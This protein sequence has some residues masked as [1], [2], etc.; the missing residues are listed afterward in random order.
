MVVLVAALVVSGASVAA[1]RGWLVRAGV[2][3]R[4]G[5]RSSHQVPTPRGGGLGI[6]AGFL[7]G[8]A[9]SSWVLPAG[10]LWGLDITDSRLTALVAG[11]LLVAAV[12]L[13]DDLHSLPVG[14]RLGAQTVGAVVAI[15]GVGTLE[16]IRLP[17]VGEARLGLLEI[18]VT[19]LWLVAVTNIYN[20]MDGIDGLAAGQAA[21]AGAFLALSALQT[22]NGAVA[23]AA[24][25]M[26]GAALGFLA[27]N[28]PP[29]RIFMGDVGSTFL[30]FAFAGLAVLGARPGDDRI[31]IY[32]TALLLAPFLFDASLTLASRVWRGE[33]WYEPHRGHL[34]QRLVNAGYSHRQVT[35]LYYLL[36]LLLGALGLIEVATGQG[37]TELFLAIGLAPLT[38]LVVWVRHVE[39]K[40]T[41]L[42][43]IN[44]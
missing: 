10:H 29:A 3:D 7:A 43:T 17:W 31:S 38:V 12:G 23:L 1:I 32:V 8:L 11:A 36:A 13:V 35:L 9:I 4:P 21:I 26:A 42:R 14:L 27:H 6:V 5:R 41:L 19:V 33:R 44:R 18:P 28:F 20:F 24:L 22:G 25:S 2:L 37:A 34:Y 30:G 39:R 40:S 15:A 16:A